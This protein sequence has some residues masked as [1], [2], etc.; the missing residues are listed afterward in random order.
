MV[1]TLVQFYYQ[2]GGLEHWNRTDNWLVGDPCENN[3][4]GVTCCLDTHPEYDWRDGYRHSADTSLATL[5]P[6]PTTLTHTHTLAPTQI[7]LHGRQ[8]S[9]RQ[10]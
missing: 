7:L 9:E 10:Q 2:T 3:W 4:Y 8:T 6:T 1:A 5:T